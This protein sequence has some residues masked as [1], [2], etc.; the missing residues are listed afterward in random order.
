[1]D[2]ID[3]EQQV[4]C[5]KEHPLPKARVHPDGVEIDEDYGGLCDGGSYVKYRCPNCYV[6]WWEQLPD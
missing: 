3:T 6:E 1:M 5:T 2:V 4:V